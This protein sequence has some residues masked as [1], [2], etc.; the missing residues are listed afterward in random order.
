MEVDLEEVGLGEAEPQGTGREARSGRHGLVVAWVVFGLAVVGAGIFLATRSELLDVDEVRLVGVSSALGE[1]AVL[2]ALA[3][4]EGS[5][6]AGVDLDAASRRVAALPRVAGVELE[7]DWP[8]SVVVW[9]VERVPAVNASAPDGRLALLDA[10]GMVIDHVSV[11]E[12]NLPIIRVDGVG[13]PGVRLPG[14]GPLLDAADAVTDDLAPWIVALVPTAAGVR[15]EL[16]GGVE[17]NLGMGNN[18]RDEMRA[19]ATILHRVELPCIVGIDVS[20][21]DIPVVRRDDLRCS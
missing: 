12:P 13:R 18:Y 5:P 3:V 11:P 6:M 7:R 21:H 14:L 9:V 4:P 17:V 15:A 20:V 10:D 8:G 1:K 19:L 2:E 16:V